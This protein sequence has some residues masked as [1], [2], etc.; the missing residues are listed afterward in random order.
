M[1]PP[2]WHLPVLPSGG[3]FWGMPTAR[4]GP[5]GSWGRPLP[6]P[7]ALSSAVTPCVR[8][9]GERLQSRSWSK[10]PEQPAVP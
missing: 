9:Q 1:V 5:G 10:A 8:P 4:L 7:A 6:L 3:A 2:G